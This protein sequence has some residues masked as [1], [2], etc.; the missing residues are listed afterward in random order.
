M[1]ITAVARVLTVVAI[2]LTV[3][4]CQAVLEPR[5]MMEVDDVV[6]AFAAQPDLPVTHPRELPLMPVSQT[7]P[8]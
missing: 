3:S 1:W 5:S 2:A 6:E 7:R 4:G 8:A